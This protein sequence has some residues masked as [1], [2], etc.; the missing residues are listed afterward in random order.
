MKSLFSRA[1]DLL[2]F[3]CLE[4]DRK[5]CFQKAAALSYSSILSLVPMAAISLSLFAGFYPIREVRTEAQSF[6]LENLA[7]QSV[8]PVSEFIDAI[9]ENLSNPSTAISI[10]G[11][12][13]L[14][15]TAIALFITI[16]EVSNAIW[17][18]RRSRPML[19]SII[20][21]W[22]ILTL[23]PILIFMS[24][25]IKIYIENLSI[26][27][28]ISNVLNL[29]KTL[30]LFLAFSFSWSGFFLL[31]HLTPNSTVKYRCSINGSLLAAILWE[32]SKIGFGVYVRYAVS[33][34]N[35]YGSI[36]AIPIFLIWVY[37]TWVIVL[38]GMTFTFC[39]QNLRWRKWLEK[40][41]TMIDPE[42]HYYAKLKSIIE[43]A[44]AFDSG[45]PVPEVDDL[46]A[47]LSIPPAIIDDG[48]NDLAEKG[49]LNKISCPGKLYHPSRATSCIALSDILA[50]L[51]SNNREVLKYL[52]DKFPGRFGSMDKVF[53]EVAA[54]TSLRELSSADSKAT[55]KRTI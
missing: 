26:F 10:F 5:F 41:R 32:L 21:F 14:F 3:T 55:P 40:R 52:G 24:I 18:I 31:F 45:Q 35:L 8:G 29:R 42:I 50:G 13:A 2:K 16:E 15:I 38:F 37:I 19:R 17:Q 12:G 25:G 48:L 20:Y 36:G 51:F 1:W 34:K 49:V 44:K 7:P 11:Y 30:Y 39:L 9:I 47:I 6:I 27:K 22:V 33:F 43:I 53:S 4:F 23:G 54:S 28:E 46:S